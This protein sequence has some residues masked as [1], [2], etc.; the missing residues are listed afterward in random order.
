MSKNKTNKTNKDYSISVRVTENGKGNNVVRKE[1]TKLGL[2]KGEAVDYYDGI[3]E[4][5]ST[6]ELL[7]EMTNNEQG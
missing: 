2:T 7:R 1:Y 6:C 3:V 4:K 5:I